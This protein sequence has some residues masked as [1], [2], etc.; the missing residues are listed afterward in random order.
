MVKSRNTVLVALQTSMVLLSKCAELV[1]WPCSAAAGISAEHGWRSHAVCEHCRPGYAGSAG[2]NQSQPADQPAQLWSSGQAQAAAGLLQ[3]QP[4]RFDPWG[5]NS[6]KQS[7]VQMQ[8]S[9]CFTHGLRSSVSDALSTEM[10]KLVPTR[11][12]SSWQQLQ[13]SRLISL[14]M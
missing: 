12:D 13:I 1:L 10:R 9:G 8:S 2:P 11:L 5:S 3:Q 14:P 6:A 4:L 7:T